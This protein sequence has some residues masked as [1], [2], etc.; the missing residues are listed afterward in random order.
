MR[1]PPSP[2]L[3]EPIASLSLI[4]SHLEESR[5]TIPWQS[6]TAPPE[7]KR[8]GLFHMKWPGSKTKADRKKAQTKSTYSQESND[9]GLPKFMSFT[10]AL[11][12]KA[13][14]MWK[15][16]GDTLVRMELEAP[17][18]H[19]INLG[20]LLP[21]GAA[22]DRSISLRY[23]VEGNEWVSAIV[24]H[25]VANQRRLSLFVVHCSGLLERSSLYPLDDHTEPRCLAISPNN[26]FIAVG[27]GT[28]VLLLHYQGAEQQWM[29]ILHIP[30]I[31]RPATA[32]FQAVG[33][34]GDNSCLA[35]STQKREAVRSDDD[36]VVF[37]HVWRCEPGSNSPLAL[38]PCR[39]PTDGLGL[40][41]IHFH[42]A[43]AMGLITGMAATP[44]PLFLTPRGRH[45]PLTPSSGVPDFRIRCSA[46]RPLPNSHQIYLLDQRNR[47]L[48]A[49]LQAQSVRVI[50]DLHA[51]RGAPKPQEDPAAMGLSESGRL[52]VFWRQ[53]TGLHVVEIETREKMGVGRCVDKEDVS[54]RWTDAVGAS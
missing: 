28:K 26:A 34:S 54:W 15:K 22:A 13:L 10:F 46:A 23:V 52:R 43:L 32:R 30:D 17:V 24:A 48:C 6:L 16:D 40:T 42:P 49:D 8:S 5:S 50:A 53:G 3:P 45:L 20:D 2:T 7:Q 33:F 18:H 9:S 47:V 51:L 35:V 27:F 41:T 36:D 31:A 4:D 21:G 38:W 44:Y 11:T 37:T 12:G 14:L 25:N 29:R 19:C 39:M 1:N